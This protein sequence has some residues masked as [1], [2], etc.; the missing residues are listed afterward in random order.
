[1]ALKYM[2]NKKDDQYYIKKI[3]E[4]IMFAIEHTKDISYDEFIC[5]EVFINAIMFSFIQIS[6]YASKLSDFYKS[7]HKEI[8]WNEMRSIRNKIVHDYDIVDGKIIYETV[9]NDFP[10]LIKMIKENI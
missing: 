6:E 2:D 7:N 4:N 3:I 5:D 10:P 8:R 9:K 1:M